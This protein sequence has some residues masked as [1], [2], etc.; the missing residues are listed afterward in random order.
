MILNF[1]VQNDINIEKNQENYLTANSGIG[2]ALLTI[3]SINITAILAGLLLLIH[4]FIS[5]KSKQILSMSSI[6]VG[7][8]ILTTAFF[9][10]ILILFKNILL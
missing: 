3:Y 8:L 4:L 10:I 6:W 9:P 1:L 7:I 2:V 5:W